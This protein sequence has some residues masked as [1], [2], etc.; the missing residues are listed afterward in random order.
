MG[1]GGG[2]LPSGRLGSA[3][4]AGQLCEMVSPGPGL[5]KKKR[6]LGIFEMFPAGS[7]EDLSPR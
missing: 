4:P 7:T 1:W 3:K 2:P 6:V 5:V